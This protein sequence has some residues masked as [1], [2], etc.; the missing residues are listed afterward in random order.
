MVG[1]SRQVDS[2]GP[3]IEKAP[4]FHVWSDAGILSSMEPPYSKGVCAKKASPRICWGFWAEM[5]SASH[6]SPSA[7]LLGLNYC[8]ISLP[9]APPL[10]FTLFQANLSE[11]ALNQM[12]V[13]L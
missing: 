7:A 12:N 10:P 4:L 5:S 13:Q 9:A 6:L 2:F 3:F 1:E 8:R 11:T